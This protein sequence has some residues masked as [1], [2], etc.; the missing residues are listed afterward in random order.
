MD[1]THL[2]LAD[3]IVPVHVRLPE[4]LVLEVVLVGGPRVRLPGPAPPHVYARVFRRRDQL[5]Q[6]KVR[7]LEKAG[8]K[9]PQRETKEGMKKRRKEGRRKG[10]KRN[11]AQARGR[12]KHKQDGRGLISGCNAAGCVARVPE[13]STWLATPRVRWI[14]HVK[15]SRAVPPAA[16]SGL[17]VYVGL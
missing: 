11:I 3:H 12:E 2:L 15:P 8:P 4:L 1:A 17:H 13:G 6:L 9:V 7:F 10:R 14:Q 5:S 16:V